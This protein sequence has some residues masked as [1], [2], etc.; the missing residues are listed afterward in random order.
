MSNRRKIIYIQHW[1]FLKSHHPYRRLKTTFNG[2]Q[3]T[4]SP[5]TPLMG[6][7][8]YKKIN[9]IDHT[10]GKSKNKSFVT[11]IWKKRLIFFHFPY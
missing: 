1:R 4:S 2:H 10:F 5:P 11:N 6:V 9:N 3:E 8:V 7:E